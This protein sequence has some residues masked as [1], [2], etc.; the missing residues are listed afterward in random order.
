MKTPVPFVLLGAILAIGTSPAHGQR[1]VNLNGGG[2][3]AEALGGQFG[4][5]AR[6]GYYPSNQPID[7]FVGGDYY[8]ASCKEDC[9]LW[10][11]RF[12]AHLHPSTPGSYPFVSGAFGGREWERGVESSSRTGFS[13]GAGYR[14]MLGK[15]RFQVEISRE[16]LGED[17]DQWVFRIG[18]G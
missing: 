2:S 3:Y 11:W 7:I 10:G 16:F 6:L 8:F 4:L 1:H 18:T 13:V 5:E 12:G 17:L 14:L 15:V 9:S